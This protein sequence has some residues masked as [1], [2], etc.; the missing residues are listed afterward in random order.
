MYRHISQLILHIDCD[1]SAKLMEMTAKVIIQNIRC[2]SIKFT[3]PI[4]NNQL[5]EPSLFS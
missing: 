1:N 4:I 2:I 5:L 3:L